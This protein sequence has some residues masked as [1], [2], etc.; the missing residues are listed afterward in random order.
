M[1][2]NLMLH[3][4]QLLAL[5]IDGV[6][7]DGSA[8]L[9]A[10]GSEEKRFS[11]HD[12]DAVNRAR[13]AGLHVV[14]ITGEEGALVEQ[15]AHRFSVKEVTCGAKDKLAALTALSERTGVPFEHMIY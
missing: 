12:L 9:T 11:F 6:I 7:T 4:L 2:Q 15:I 10:D 13:R 8:T 3:S 5:D 1:L 14:F